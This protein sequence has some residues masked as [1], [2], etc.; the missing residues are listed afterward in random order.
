M[1]NIDDD[2]FVKLPD[3]HPITPTDEPFNSNSIPS[4]TIPIKY[5]TFLNLLIIL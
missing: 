2:N 5:Q 1:V 3:R 4:D